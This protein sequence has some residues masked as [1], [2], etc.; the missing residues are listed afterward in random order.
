MPVV[1]TAGEDAASPGAARPTGRTFT[2]EILPPE[3]SIEAVATSL[4]GKHEAWIERFHGT[5]RFSLDDVSASRVNVDFDMT[6]L[7]MGLPGLTRAVRSP[8]FFD[9]QR[10]PRGVFASTKVER[11]SGKNTYRVTGTL[12]LHGVTR[13]VSFEAVV[14]PGDG[15]ATARG[16]VRLSRRDFGIVFDGPFDKLADD[17][18]AVRIWAQGATP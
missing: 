10:Y 18:I 8:A 5:V 4:A 17:I 3:S 12:E 2:L 13:P 6:T 1:P 7:T 14:V 16:D 9:V 11:T 15:W